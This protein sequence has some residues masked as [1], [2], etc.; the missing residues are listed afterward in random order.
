MKTWEM[1]KELTE[2]PNKVFRLKNTYNPYDIPVEI[3]VTG[4]TIISLDDIDYFHIDDEGE[5]YILW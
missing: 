3:E 4:E 1:L 5:W 2:Y